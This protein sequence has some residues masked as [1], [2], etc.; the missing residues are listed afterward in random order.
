MEKFI[1]FFV[2]HWDEVLLALTSLVTAA[3][4]I[5][6]LTPNKTD[7]AII[8]KILKMINFFALKKLQ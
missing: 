3:S 2:A 4:I 1:P 6:R 7:D 8:N 5:A